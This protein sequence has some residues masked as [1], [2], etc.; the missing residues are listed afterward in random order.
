MGA[1]MGEEKM[2]NGFSDLAERE[3]CGIETGRYTTRAT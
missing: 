2:G 3:G 1:R